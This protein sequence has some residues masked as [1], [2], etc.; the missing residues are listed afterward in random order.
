MSF[1]YTSKFIFNMAMNVAVRSAYQVTYLPELNNNHYDKY[2][3]SA[4]MKLPWSDCYC[5]SFFQ[6]PFRNVAWHCLQKA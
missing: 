1:C 5:C 3:F 4:I 2:P 6:Y